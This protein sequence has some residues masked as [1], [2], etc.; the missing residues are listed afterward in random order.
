MTIA[1]RFGSG[2]G[3]IESPL[4]RET[5]TAREWWRVW[6]LP[7]TEIPDTV[8]QF[9]GTAETVEADAPRMR[10]VAGVRGVRLPVD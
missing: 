5:E 7:S 8:D 4:C 9:K 3:A 2:G 10:L 6:R 1:C